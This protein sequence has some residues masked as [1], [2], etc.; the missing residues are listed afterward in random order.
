MDVVNIPLTD[1]C[2]YQ[3]VIQLMQEMHTTKWY[4]KPSG[5][6]SVAQLLKT[7]DILAQDMAC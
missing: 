7:A 2:L 6:L 3:Y 5:K 4:S 1:T